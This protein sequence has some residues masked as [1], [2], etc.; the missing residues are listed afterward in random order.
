MAKQKEELADLEKA[1]LLENA[2][3]KAEQDTIEKLDA[4]QDLFAKAMSDPSQMKTVGDY[5]K[6]GRR[7]DITHKELVGKLIILQRC[8]VINTKYGEAML[9]DIDVEGYQKSALLGGTV[10]IDQLKELEVNLPVC[11]VIRKPA[12]A[13]CLFPPSP[14]EIQAYKDNYL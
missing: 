1:E 12:R 10:L 11:A 9:V 3:S 7:W 8:K 13:Y 2:Y 6:T 5:I 14:E 4:H